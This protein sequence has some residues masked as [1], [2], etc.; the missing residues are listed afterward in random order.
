MALLA[1]AVVALGF[2]LTRDGQDAAAPGDARYVCPMHPRVT[3]AVQG[4]CPICGMALLGIGTFERDEAT[5]ATGRAVDARGAIDASELLA[6]GAG[7]FAPHLVG[8]SP[9]PVRRHVLRD[10]LYAPAWVAREGEAIALVYA[11]E[12]AALESAERATFSPTADPGAAWEAR[13]AP[14]PIERSDRSTSRVRFELARPSGSR[15]AL[16]APGTVGWVRL[17]PRPRSAE[18]VPANAVLESA[19]GPHVLVVSAA[20]GTVSRRAVELGRVSTG[21][22][23]VLSGLDLREEVVSTNAFF[24]DAERRLR[25]ARRIAGEG[26]P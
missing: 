3:A 12:A 21:L 9:S 4:A 22:A 7:R 15:A 19:D 8:D 17:K 23:A 14:A 25:D 10:A 5:T 26:P 2:G 13:R 16:P 18:V 20:R 11:D 6:S 24:W 1:L